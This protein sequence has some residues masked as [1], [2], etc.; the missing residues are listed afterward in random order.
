MLFKDKIKAKLD[1]AVSEPIRNAYT[2]AIF[3]TVLACVA[4]FLAVVRK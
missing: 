3:A 1:T 2:L 4:I